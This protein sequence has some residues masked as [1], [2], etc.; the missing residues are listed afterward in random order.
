MVQETIISTTQKKMAIVVIH[1]I[2][3]QKPFETLDSFVKK[4]AEEYNFKRSK[5]TLKHNLV[6]FENW[7]ESCISLIPEDKTYKQIDVLEYYWSHMTQRKITMSEVTDWVLNVARGGSKFHLY[8]DQQVDISHRDDDALFNDYGELKISEYLASILCI[9]GWSKPLF[10]LLF[11]CKETIPFLRNLKPAFEGV[12][13]IPVLGLV[14]KGFGLAGRLLKPLFSRI[15]VDYIGDIALY[16]TTDVKSEY[17]ETRKKILDTAV[18]K[19]KLLALNKDYDEILLCGHSLGSVIAYDV[20]DRLNILMNKTEVIEKDKDNTIMPEHAPK[21][22]GIITFGSPLDKVAFF[23]NEYIDQNKQ[24]IRHEIVSQL[25]T[26][27]RS[28]ASPKK[29]STHQF[30]KRIRGRKQLL[31]YLTISCVRGSLHRKDITY[32]INIESGAGYHIQIQQIES[33]KQLFHYTMHGLLHL[34]AINYP[35]KVPVLLKSREQ[36][37]G[38]RFLYRISRLFRRKKAQ[39]PTPIINVDRGLKDPLR[40]IPWLNFWTPFDVISG[41]LDA[42]HEVINLNL[43]DEEDI[44]VFLEK[45]RDPSNLLALSVKSTSY[46]GKLPSRTKKLLPWNK[47]QRFINSHRGYWQSADMYDCII[48]RFM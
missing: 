12:E 11:G 8:Q 31:G 22:R 19:I 17:F 9:S 5:V 42:Y 44:A 35:I 1:G 20:I 48:S 45:H 28:H 39:A 24:P 4:F 46:V 15:M 21:F 40:N 29:A 13:T 36:L 25:H 23:F 34:N 47:A 37:I 3:E 18:D 41:Y 26:F 2:G 16:C 38:Y 43:S 30:K 6:W 32:P 33:R 14:T 27:R 7:G 10:K